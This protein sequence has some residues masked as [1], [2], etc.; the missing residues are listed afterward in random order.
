MLAL[1][2]GGGS[3]T[4]AP[5]VLR[6]AR[7]HGR[8]V[9]AAGDACPAS[10]LPEVLLAQGLSSSRGVLEPAGVRTVDLLGRALAAEERGWP[11][12]NG[13]RR[14]SLPPWLLVV[15]MSSEKRGGET[16]GLDAETDRERATAGGGDPAAA[17]AEMTLRTTLERRV[18]ESLRSLDAVRALLQ[19]PAASARQDNEGRG[20]RAA[21]DEAAEKLA[22]LTASVDPATAL[23]E[24]TLREWLACGAATR[25]DAGDREDG[26][27]SARG[28]RG[29]N[30]RRQGGAKQAPDAES[31]GRASD[32]A[33]ALAFRCEAAGDTEA[34][35]SHVDGFQA[36]PFGA[37]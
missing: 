9:G 23:F 13:S 24:G 26:E 16:L 27:T 12:R 8:L 25:K 11:A 10:L 7:E 35:V 31:S 37:P 5:L 34:M 19:D 30:L 36:R 15:M 20:L 28:G 22:S 29:V 1:H 32:D 14:G 33:L 6:Y 17:A 3:V 4:C 21:Q 18:S 2:S